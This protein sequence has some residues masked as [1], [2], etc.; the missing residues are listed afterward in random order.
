MFRTC[1]TQS[2]RCVA[3][4]SSTSLFHTSA[5]VSA[6]PRKLT[7]KAKEER[8]AEKREKA[9]ANRPSVILGTRSGEEWRWEQCD[10]AKVLVKE[11]GLAGPPAMQPI[12]VSVGTVHVP[13]QFAYGVTKDDA[14][15]LF[16]KLPEMS[17]YQGVKDHKDTEKMNETWRLGVVRELKK[18]TEFAKAID[19]RN[20]D[21]EGIAYENRRRIIAEFSAPEN[22][23][24]P[25][26]TE[27]QAAILTYRIRNLWNHLTTNKKDVG[28]RL[29][30]RKLVHHRAKILKY[31]KRTHR[32]RYDILLERLALEPESV[33]GELIV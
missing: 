29:G 26:R 2:T 14:K 21:A 24:D 28:N 30:L 11:A 31:L 17:A 6:A 25:G 18:A 10:L 3:S 20:A 1:L 22:P 13:K 12:E 8:K 33:E 16:D 15:L 9:L 4:S 19:L 5:I 23:F 32:Q 27:V 7:N